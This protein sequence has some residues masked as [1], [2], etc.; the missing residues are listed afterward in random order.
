M[1]SGGDA[2]I[3]LVVY[4]AGGT[5]HRGACHLA[6]RPRRGHDAGVTRITLLP[7]TVNPSG[8][9][10]SIRPMK[11]VLTSYIRT[12]AGAVPVPPVAPGTDQH[13]REAESAEEQP[14]GGVDRRIRPAGWTNRS[15]SATLARGSPFRRSRDRPP[16]AWSCRS[17][18]PPQAR[19]VYQR[20]RKG[21]IRGSHGSCLPGGASQA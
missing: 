11:H 15:G 20:R 7:A 6:L 8:L 14:K 4:P 5:G 21:R 16:G 19:G 18:P 10:H 1:G 12:P 2:N 9:V 13:L 3:R 17:R